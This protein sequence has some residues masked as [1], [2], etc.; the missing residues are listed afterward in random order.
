M[1][2]TGV[3]QASIDPE[4]DAWILTAARFPQATPAIMAA[5][6]AQLADPNMTRL[7]Q[8]IGRIADNW[9]DEQLLRETA[10]LMNELLEQ[11]A[12]R[13]ELNQ[14]DEQTPDAAFVHLMDSFAEGAHPVVARLRELIAERGW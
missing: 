12:A 10:D 3:P 6:T 7:Y 4:R 5:K 11:A 13:G 8:L 14:Q 1:R 2:A 9:E